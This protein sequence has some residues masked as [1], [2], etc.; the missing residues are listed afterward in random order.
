[1]SRKLSGKA[2][3]MRRRKPTLDQTY[4][5]FKDVPAMRA[6]KRRLDKKLKRKRERMMELQSDIYILEDRL[7]RVDWHLEQCG[8]QDT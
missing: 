8:E 7:R 2:V 1:M 3:D 4:T 5:V 6:E